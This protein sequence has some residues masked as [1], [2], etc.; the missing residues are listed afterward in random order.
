MAGTGRTP[1]ER[2]TGRDLVDGMTTAW[3]REMPEVDLAIVELT[4]RAARL[5]VILQDRLAA[6][7]EPWSLTR[8]DFN[9]LNV[10]RGAGSPYELRPSDMHERLMLTAGGVSNVLGRL[11]RA[12]LVE[13]RRDESDGRG[14]WVRLTPRG[15]ETAE[16]TMR[17]WAAEQEV[18]YRDV[19][20]SQARVASAALREVLLAIGDYEPGPPQSRSPTTEKS[21]GDTGTA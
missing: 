5:G 9:V 19:T 12:E 10:L 17:A 16:A 1:V 7:L 4:R 2:G 11:L 13:R 21:T 8:A 18:L 20:E 3:R 15:V 6:C 14:L